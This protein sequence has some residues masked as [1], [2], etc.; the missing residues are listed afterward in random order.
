MHMSKSFLFNANY[1]KQIIKFKKNQARDT[2]FFNFNYRTIKFVEIHTHT[3]TKKN[4][5]VVSIK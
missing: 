5:I 4:I 3:H 2:T 1:L